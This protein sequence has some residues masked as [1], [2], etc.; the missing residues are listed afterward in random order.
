[1]SGIENLSEKELTRVLT[2]AGFILVAFELAK[3]MI[4]NPIKVFYEHVTFVEGMPFKSYEEDVLSRH[5]YQFEATLLYLKDFMES[6][7]S[8]DVLTLQTLRRHRNDLAHDLPNILGTLDLEHHLPLLEKADRVLFKLSNY[9]TYME[10]G[11]DPAFKNKGIDWDTI[12][13]PEYMLFEDILHKVRILRN[14]RK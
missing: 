10:I 9:L 12:K 11:S 13:G 7:D 4:V 14:A 1:M 3:S 8:E 2:Y 6:I 5:K